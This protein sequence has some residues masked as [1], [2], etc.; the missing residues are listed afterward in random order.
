M[1]LH[2]IASNRDAARATKHL[3]PAISQRV[4]LGQEVV[5]GELLPDEQFKRPRIDRRRNRPALAREFLLHYGIE[6]NGYTGKYYQR[7]NG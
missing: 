7:Y 2:G 6:V 5:L 1:H 4:E 3:F